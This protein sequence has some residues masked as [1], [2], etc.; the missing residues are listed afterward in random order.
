[1]INKIPHVINTCWSQGMVQ[2]GMTGNPVERWLG[3]TY[4]KQYFRHWTK[5]TLVAVCQTCEGAHIIECMLIDKYKEF[6]CSDNNEYM[7]GVGL[8]GRVR[9]KMVYGMYTCLHYERTCPCRRGCKAGARGLTEIIKL[10][11]CTL[12]R[13]SEILIRAGRI[14]HEGRARFD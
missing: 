12:F 6:R 1:M 13:F 7:T 2:P 9:T 8:G 5:M 11:K 14:D 4:P 3:G 10:E